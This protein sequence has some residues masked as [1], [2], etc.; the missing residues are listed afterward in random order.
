MTLMMRASGGL[1]GGLLLGMMLAT[2]PVRADVTG[3]Y[4]G[5]LTPKK[6][7][8]PIAAAAVFSQL[9][10]TVSGTVALPADLLSFGG[11][12]L[13][14]G[15][16]TPKK[17]KVSGIGTNGVSFK[18]RGKIVGTTLSGKARLKGGAGKL[19]GK[20]ALTLNPPTDGSGCDGVY[21]ANE[22]F[23]VDQVLAQALQACKSCHGPDLQAGATRLHVDDN[24]PLATARA[25]APL[26]DSVSPAT[27]RILEKPLN[28]LPH[29]GGQ[30]LQPGS[31]AEQILTQ[32]V[33][34]I[35]N[36]ACN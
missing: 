2:S 10:K 31:N 22:T 9:D 12:Y 13:V 11:A 17:V 4:D 7:T 32:W 20:L 5:G 19:S 23:F 28:V 15:K 18:Y 36:A 35:A 8:E 6:E 34:L 30:Q 14:T 25:I 29:G 21:T 27:S 33:D 26:V 24:D 3:S 1:C 16:A